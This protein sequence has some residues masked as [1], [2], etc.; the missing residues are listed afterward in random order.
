MKPNPPIPQS[1]PVAKVPRPSQ[2]TSLSRR[3]WAVTL[4]AG[5]LLAAGSVGV[6]W[7][8]ARPREQGAATRASE[9]S[10]VDFSLTDTA[11]QRVTRQD[12]AGRILVVSFAFTSCSLSCLAVNDR[13]AELQRALAGVEDVCLVS[14]TVDPRTDT[15]ATLGRFAAR[16][17]ADPRRWRFLTGEKAE[18]YRLI[19]SSFL[20]R[21]RQ[22]E[23]LIP[24][25]FANSDYLQIVD[26]AGRVRE[27][28]P[29]LQPGVVPKVLSAI[30]RLRRE[31]VSS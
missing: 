9:R 2:R 8:T 6:A 19:E 3:E 10:L 15:P 7:L 28:F 30:E 26:R 11:G 14:L 27:S 1:Q 16:Y 17:G 24:G 29:G 22:L 25:G 5:L 21:S 4:G 31:A 23:T 12:F 18:V 20:S 13:M